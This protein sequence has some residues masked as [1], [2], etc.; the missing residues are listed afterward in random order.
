MS[1]AP[2]FTNAVSSAP[3]GASQLRCAFWSQSSLA[4]M[5]ARRDVCAYR[6]ADLSLDTAAATTSGSALNF[7]VMNCS[8]APLSLTTES[9]MSLSSL[10]SAAAYWK[11][12]ASSSAHWRTKSLSE[13]SSFDA[14][15]MAEPLPLFAASSTRLRSRRSLS[16]ACASAAP[17]AATASRTKARSS[18][19]PAEASF[20]EAPLSFAASSTSWRSWRSSDVAYCRARPLLDR[21]A[22]YMRSRSPQTSGGALSS[23]FQSWPTAARQH[24]DRQLVTFADEG[25]SSWKPP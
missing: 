8:A 23:S 11:A 10:S 18:R 4:P 16:L 9:A 7:G 2:G 24:R 13:A 22:V 14:P 25:A 19:R 12:S 17:S 5:S 6:S 3:S 21:M 1:I 20:S 15:F